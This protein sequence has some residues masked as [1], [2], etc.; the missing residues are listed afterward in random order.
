MATLRSAMRRRS[1]S[2][3]RAT[4]RPPRDRLG[5]RRRRSARRSRC[6][7]GRAGSTGA[8]PRGAAHA[9]HRGSTSRRG[10]RDRDRGG[11]SLRRPRSQSRRP[12]APRTGCAGRP[13]PETSATSAST[14][15]SMVMPRTDATRRISSDAGSSAAQAVAIAS[16]SE[17]RRS[18]ARLS[19]SMSNGFPWPERT[20]AST[21]RASHSS[22]GR[23]ARRSR[24]KR[25]A[26]RGPRAAR[27]R[28]V[29][30]GDC[31]SSSS[32]PVTG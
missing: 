12:R 2:P 25:D 31:A 5:T 7:V 18:V 11:T 21:E 28:T 17:A 22:G 24:T 30:D 9:E 4:R 16:S 8:L 19:A 29:A 26:A 13:A 3:P 15:G 27:C 20:M 6:W 1:R 32:T 23:P 10:T 14:S